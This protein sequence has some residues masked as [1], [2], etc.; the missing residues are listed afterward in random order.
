MT[1]SPVAA[2][3]VGANPG[4][5]VHIALLGIVVVIALLVFGIVRWRNKREA[6]EAAI[7]SSTDSGDKKDT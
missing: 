3:L 7:H 6:A 2:G 4:P 1:A 5:A